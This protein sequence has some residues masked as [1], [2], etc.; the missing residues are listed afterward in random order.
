MDNNLPRVS[1][2]IPT[3]NRANYLPEA[4]RSVLAQSLRPF[5]VI[6]VDDGS[7]DNTRE[8]VHSFDSRI[9]YFW[10]DHRGVAAA[11]NLGLEVAQGEIIAWLD[12]DDLWE[13][14]F[15]ATLV[16]LLIQDEKLD[17]VYC[18]LAHIDP[19]GSLLPTSSEKV[20]PPEDLFSSLIESDFIVTPAIVVRKKCYEQVGPFDL[21]F[22]I[23]EDY[24][25][26]LRLAKVFTIMGIARVLVKIRVSQNSTMMRDTDA[27]CQS[28]IALTQK[29]FGACEGNPNTWSDDKRRAYAYAFLTCCIRH[30]QDSNHDKGWHF[31]E[32][33]A[34]LWPQLM[35]R[36]DVFYEL[37]CSDQ[38]RG[39]RGQT[40]LLNIK[41]NSAELLKRLN[42][43]FAKGDASLRSMRR[44]GYGN[45]YLTLGI[46]SDQAGDWAQARSYLFHAVT[47]NPNLLLSY[48][49][50]RQILKLYSGQRLVGLMRTLRGISQ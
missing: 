39:Y 21:Q 7:S 32:K 15:L 26:W 40:H 4:L 36:L 2:I 19:A 14:E 12:S 20:V 41:G 31:L 47:I 35:D 23:C 5:E 17:G 33:A 45:A 43:L 50:V 46:L 37:A 1:V 22:R 11:R 9:H 29:H 44:K 28:R 25:M 10:Q 18:G 6:V 34:S 8:V 38:P 16:P 27:L 48:S 13:S 49:V 24:D 3:Y 30:I 42:V